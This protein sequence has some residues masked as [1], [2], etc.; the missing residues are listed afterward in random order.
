MAD[1][2]KLFAFSPLATQDTKKCIFVD[3]ISENELQLLLDYLNGQP[4][5]SDDK[6]G[7]ILFGSSN[8]KQ[9]E[10]VVRRYFDIFN[11]D[12]ILQYFEQNQMLLWITTATIEGM[13]KE[14]KLSKFVA[15][16]QAMVSKEG[17]IVIGYQTIKSKRQ[18]TFKGKIVDREGR[19]LPCYRLRL[20]DKDIISNDDFLDWAFVSNGGEFELVYDDKSFQDFQ[21]LKFKADGKPELILEVDKLVGGNTP[22]KRILSCK[23]FKYGKDKFFPHGYILIER[24]A[25]GELFLFDQNR[26]P[27]VKYC[28]REDP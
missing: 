20:I 13:E 8:P 28:E 5:P 22:F 18:Y 14:P 7:L 15:V 6:N 11:K 19:E 2:Y 1:R 25:S 17:V 3:E 24:D 12:K 10:Q 9:F 23:L 27:L 16:L 4:I 21:F 26:T